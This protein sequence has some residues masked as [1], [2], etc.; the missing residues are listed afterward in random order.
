MSELYDDIAYLSQEIGPR[1]AGTEEENQAAQFIAERFDKS[2]GLKAEVE[3]FACSNQPGLTSPI[4]FGVSALVSLV[5]IFF[6]VLTVAAFIVT[7][8]CALLIALEL[9]DKPVLSRMFQRGVSQNVI[10]KYLPAQ[11]GRARRRKIILVANYDSGRVEPELGVLGS[12]LP[13]IQKIVCCAAALLPLFWLIAIFAGVGMVM[14]V[15]IAVLSVLALLPVIQFVIHRASS[16]NEA[17]NNNAAGVSSLVEVA[18]RVQDG[19]WEELPEFE[20][21]QEP[22]IYGLD[23]AEQEG[24]LP[25]GAPI[26]YE[27]E[28][29]AAIG[30]PAEK[31][32]EEDA[33]FQRAETRAVF[34]GQVPLDAAEGAAVETSDGSDGEQETSKEQEPDGESGHAVP[35]WFAAAQKKANKPK[36]TGTVKRSRYA[37]ALDA[38]VAESSM[39]FA[40]ANK[41]LE[42]EAEQ[43]LQARARDIVEVS[44]PESPDDIPPRPQVAE[45]SKASFDSAPASQIGGT[46]PPHDF[47]AIPTRSADIPAAAPAQPAPPEK[48]ES[49]QDAPTMPV[50]EGAA[51]SDPSAT[52]AIPPLDV[53]SLRDELKAVPDPSRDTAAERL[54]KRPSRHVEPAQR[55][56]QNRVMVD[57]TDEISPIASSEAVSARKEP[58]PARSVP[59]VTLPQVP[60]TSPDLPPLDSFKQR[61][62][63]AQAE[64]ASADPSLSSRIPRIEA[65]GSD[66]FAQ[67]PDNKR[68]ALRQ[69]LP[70]M[71]GTISA[72]PPQPEN[73]A[74]SLT[75]SFA[76]VGAERTFAPVGDELVADI[77]PEERYVDDADD[78]AFDEN[79][80]VTGAYAGPGYMEMPDKHRGL[81][82]RLFH[83]K[84]KDEPEEE[85]AAEWLGVDENFNPTE[86]GARRGGWESFQNESGDYEYGQAPD[87]GYVYDDYVDYENYVE[88][89]D[90]GKTKRW[91]GGAFS[92]IRSSVGRDDA[93]AEDAQTRRRDRR[94]VEPM[95]AEFAEVAGLAAAKYAA[96]NEGD[97]IADETKRV[98]GFRNAGI[99]TEVWFVALGAEHAGNAG[100]KAFLSEH[101]SELR[102]S[103]VINL[104]GI[105]AGDLTAIEEEGLILSRRSSSRVK[106]YLHSAAQ[107]SG[108]NPA[109]RSMK[110]RESAATVAMR[111]GLQ[112]VTLAGMDGAKP[113]YYAQGDDVLEAVD[114]EILDQNIMFVENILK[115][116]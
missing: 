76:A 4:L 45:G 78:S 102:G 11:E 63:L 71:S 77:A 8:V 20:E 104:E 48:S 83:R 55:R 103:V 7:L 57:G 5:G 56:T 18:R 110:W 109:V 34:T 66:Q 22:R 42:D 35:A 97:Q 3:E 99:T 33:S 70:S 49:V 65:N 111:R 53:S 106:R 21:G 64:E 114:E 40:E 1:P 79:A 51:P 29:N 16:Y 54:Q 46:E 2:A 100:M 86:V 92:R 31:A 13:I 43:R 15:L 112:A 26:E 91:N 115:N 81:L 39:Y 60:A 19:A 116:V 73:K 95:P 74:V 14:M 17:A 23:A 90:L 69:T 47:S 32:S 24:V 10:A 88:T 44:A 108:F 68:A 82:G 28:P 75:G 85:N 96:E 37:D 59:A 93:S 94:N 89:D 50:Q 52:T 107:A 6:P 84:K 58:Q 62:P 25:E 87:D 9:L 61:A 113:A 30:I 12:F 72:V 98:Y 80:T 67:L 101:A 27:V 105:G 41:V 38:A 36:S